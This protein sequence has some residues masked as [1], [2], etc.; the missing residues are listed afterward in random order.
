MEIDWERLAV[1]LALVSIT[2]AA[3]HFTLG[4]WLKDNELARRVIGIGTTLLLIPF[5]IPYDLATLVTAF[6]GFTAGGLTLAVIASQEER[7]AQQQRA[8]KIKRE[9]RQEVSN[10]PTSDRQRDSLV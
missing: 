4:Q 10:A 6:L 1:Y 7:M 5:T 3:E 8:A 2:L 9:I